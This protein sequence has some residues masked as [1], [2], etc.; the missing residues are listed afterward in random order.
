MNVVPIDVAPSLANLLFEKKPV[1][2]TSATLAVNGDISYFQRHVGCTD[3]R[4]LVLD[5]PF[6]YEKQVT[7]HIASDMPEPRNAELFNKKAVIHIERFLQQPGGRAFVLF[8]SYGMMRSMAKSMMNFF[9]EEKMTL[10]IQGED[11]S[12]RKMLEEFRQR[13]R[14]VIFGTS[15]FWTGVDGPGDALQNVTIRWLRP[16]TSWWSRGE[17]APSLS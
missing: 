2:V 8:T 12:P 13:E 5:S 6:D 4:A 10:L 17:G 15:S 3:A 16:G 11:L 9:D 1:I 14:A 7:V